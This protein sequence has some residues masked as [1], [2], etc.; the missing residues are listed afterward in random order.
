MVAPL[1]WSSPDRN[2]K[3]SFLLLL[4]GRNKYD[5]FVALNTTRRS[6]R[7]H[8]SNQSKAACP[9]K[10]APKSAHEPLSNRAI[11]PAHSH[12]RSP[13]CHVVLLLI[14]DDAGEG[15]RFQAA[16]DSAPCFNAA[17]SALIACDSSP[18]ASAALLAAVPLVRLPLAL[19]DLDRPAEYRVEVSD[20]LRC[21]AANLHAQGR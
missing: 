5:S 19:R 7:R 6:S 9:P 14:H 4:S 11:A 17:G 10:S 3:R 18:A 15:A 1:Y 2:C 12:H 8:Y 20:G 13:Y 21:L 16:L